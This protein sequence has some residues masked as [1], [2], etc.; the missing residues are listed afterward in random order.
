MKKDTYKDKFDLAGKRVAV[1]ATDGFEQSELMKPVEAL[2]ECGVKVDIITPEG[3]AIRGWSEK[4]WGQTI[5]ADHSLETADPTH[6]DGLLLPGGVM[7]SDALRELQDAQDFVR[8]F[9]SEGKPSFVICHGAQI[10]IDADL[11]EGRRMTSYSSI[12]PDLRNAGA[13]WEDAEVVVDD[14]F[15]TSRSPDDLP[16]FCA[17]MCEELAEGIHAG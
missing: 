7:N 15:V 3:A 11:V 8:H 14:G 6:Y 16:A 2:Q 1:V 12:A 4:N 9:F 17:K 10:L 13:D 5:K